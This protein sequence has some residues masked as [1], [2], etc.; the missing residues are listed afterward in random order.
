MAKSKKQ[1]SDAE[2]NDP[3]SEFQDLKVTGRKEHEDDGG[4]LEQEDEKD[5]IV[6]K[7]ALRDDFCD[8][9]FEKTSG[10]GL[11]DEYKVKGKYGTVMPALQ[12]AFANL[13]IHLAIIDDVFKNG[14]IEFESLAEVK[15]H[16]LAHL[17]VVTGFAI[18]GKDDNE[19][20]SL[21]GNKYLSAGGR[22]ELEGPKIPID[23][24]SSYKWY[25]E[26]KEAITIA[27]DEVAK[28]HDGH[29]IP[30]KVE[31]ESEEVTQLT[32]MSPEA[33]QEHHEQDHADQFAEAEL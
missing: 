12:E 28:Y 25:N 33:A 23:N 15:N 5:M 8:Y 19:S 29:C 13:N 27:R 21:I 18:K 17:Y 20:V 24:L 22:M 7:A 31:T 14:G 30:V 3:L 1:K 11:G 9:S 26:L 32:I 10:V 16:D 2:Q 6:T 4:E